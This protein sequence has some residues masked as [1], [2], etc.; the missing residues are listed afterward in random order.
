MKLWGQMNSWNLKKKITF[1]LTLT[2]L[3]TSVII[4]MLSTI[5][6]AFY[7]TRQARDLAKA[8][9]ST[10]VFSYDDTLK[11]YQELAVAM[12]I[13]DDVQK[14]C[15]SPYESGG[16][17]EMESGIVYNYL[18]SMLNVRSNL[19][20]AVVEKEKNQRYVYKG[21]T[22]VVDAKFDM[23]Y[24]K[25]YKKSLPAK[26]GS[27]VRFSFGSNYFR[28]GRYTLTLY[29]PIYSTETIH[30]NLGMLVLNLG[31]SL[32]EQLHKEGLGQM[33]SELFLMDCNGEIVSISNQK[34]IGEKVSYAEKIQDGSG[35][36]QE[37]GTLINYQ[38]V[39]NWNYY[40]IN[41]IPIFEIYKDRVKAMALLLAV[42]LGMT[43]FSIVILRKMI[44][45]FYEPMNRVV[46]TMDGVSEGKLDERIDMRSM[47]ADSR[48]LAEGFNGMMDKID[49][50]M[51]QV[52]LEQHQIEQISFNALYAQIKPHFLYNTLECIHW[53]AV[54]DGNQEISVMVKAMAQYYRVCLSRGKEL[55]ELEQ[56]LEHIRSYLV[57]QNMRYDNIIDLEDQIPKGFY[58]IKI[59]KMTLQPLVENAI[60]HGIRIKEG[61]KGRIILKIQRRGEDVYLYLEDSGSGME[62]KEIDE[63]NQSLSQ[64]DET[65]GYGVRNV[66]KRMELMFGKGY[67]LCY[68]KNEHG[69]VTVEIHLPFNVAAEDKGVM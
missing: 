3:M 41:E 23:M 43:A 36:F 54:A 61:G 50:L 51:E 44:N 63:M 64:Y 68:F 48:K 49:M 45:S 38:K 53:Q 60:Y 10:I 28:D 8:Q 2:M 19:N 46:T 13:E 37:Q 22:S 21:N 11:Q 20:F 27:S 47:D 35:S 7:M 5:S 58:S 62:Q 33:N 65:F 26:K 56:E 31:D 24:Q 14:Y 18:N 52:K 66:N 17:Y 9:L 55:I 15:K 69:G 12:V 39:G 30:E 6:A 40:L 59:P 16:G 32:V 57:I 25:D 1:F 34:R 29:H 67:G 42:S 4:M